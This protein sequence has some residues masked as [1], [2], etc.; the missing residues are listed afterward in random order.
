[1]FW[2]DVTWR[3]LQD[4]GLSR[5]SYAMPG[6]PTW[7]QE[8]PPTAAQIRRQWNR[9]A[10]ERAAAPDFTIVDDAGRVVGIGE[11][12]EFSRR[13]GERPE[14]FYKRVAEVY[15]RLQLTSRA[16]TAGVS[17]LAGVPKSTAVAWVHQA[18]RRG[19]L[20][21]HEKSKEPG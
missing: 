2:K 10:P 18:R 16:P 15:Q 19:L 8:E 9:R 3:G 7:R 14:D 1:V 4:L 13:A 20:P 17:R 6:A 5:I 21:P 11:V 12:K